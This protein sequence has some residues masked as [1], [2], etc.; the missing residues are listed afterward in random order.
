MSSTAPASWK[1]H[2]QRRNK[3]SCCKIRKQS[4][5]SRSQR[6]G[7]PCALPAGPGCIVRKRFGEFVQSANSPNLFASLCS[8]LPGGA[9]PSPTMWT[10]L[11]ASFAA[12]PFIVQFSVLWAVV[13][14]LKTQNSKLFI[15]WRPLPR[16]K[17]LPDP[18][19]GSGG[20][21][22]AAGVGLPPRPDCSSASGPPGPP[23]GQAAP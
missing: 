5:S 23:Q 19:P 7:G 10:G 3:R 16:S 21:P 22:P 14:F 15:C 12:R 9:S 17:A 11:C 2:W 20:S 4:A 1:K 13:A 18:L 6:R 8:L